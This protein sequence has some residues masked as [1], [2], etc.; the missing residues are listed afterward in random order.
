MIRDLVEGV[1]GDTSKIEDR[2]PLTKGSRYS[3]RFGDLRV[4]MDSTTS[5]PYPWVSI[6]DRTRGHVATF[7]FKDQELMLGILLLFVSEEPEDG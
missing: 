3:E 1:G 7:Q 2:H 6:H 4:Y 5:N